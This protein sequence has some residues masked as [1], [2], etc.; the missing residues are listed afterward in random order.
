MEAYPKTRSTWCLAAIALLIC[1]SSA[2]ST[3][4]QV[5]KI[6]RPRR[7]YGDSPG[8]RRVQGEQRYSVIRGEVTPGFSPLPWSCH[9]LLARYGT[10]DMTS[11]GLERQ[12]NRAIFAR[13]PGYSTHFQMN[14]ALPL[15]SADLSPE[16]ALNYYQERL[17]LLGRNLKEKYEQTPQVVNTPCPAQQKAKVQLQLQCKR[18]ER[19]CQLRSLRVS[20]DVHLRYHGRASLYPPTNASGADDILRCSRYGRGRLAAAKTGSSAPIGSGIFS[21]CLGAFLVVVYLAFGFNDITSA[22]LLQVAFNPRGLDAMGVLGWIVLSAALSF[23]AT[24][25]FSLFVSSRFKSPLAALALSA[26]VVSYPR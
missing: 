1:L 13:V 18:D 15:T 6:H 4:R 19:L 26:A 23:L 22:E 3:V 7:V 5:V 9:E 17:S 10:A 20:C 25:S 16:R 24:C 14:S 12:S 2:F 8:Y 11:T 21:L